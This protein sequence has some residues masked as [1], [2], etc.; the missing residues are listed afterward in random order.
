MTLFNGL[1]VYHRLALTAGLVLVAHTVVHLAMGMV[2]S[3]QRVGW[4]L[5]FGLYLTIM[6]IIDICKEQP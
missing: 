1:V 6:S 4:M 5:G 3:P 2:G